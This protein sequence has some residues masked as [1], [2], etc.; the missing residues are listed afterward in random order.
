MFVK[1]AR[2]LPRVAV[3]FPELGSQEYLTDEEGRIEVELG[4]GTH[5]VEVR[6]GE[7]WGRYRLDADVRSSL[8]VVDTGARASS[9]G[10]RSTDAYLDFGDPRLAERYQ[11]AKL[12]GRGGMGVVVEATDTLL[13]RKVAIKMLNDQLHD[14]P[15]AE[16]IFLTEARAMAKLSHPN[17]VAVHDVIAGDSRTLMVVEYIEGRSLES[18]IMEAGDGLPEQTVVAVGASLC[19]AF[20]YLHS[21]GV[22]HR[23]LKPANVMIQPD[24]AL[25]LIDFGLARSLEHI[26]MRG[27][28]VRGTPAYMAPEQVLGGELG[29]AT[30]IY[31][32]GV[33]L[34]E[35]LSGRLPFETGNVA[36]AHVHTEPPRIDELVA[37]LDPGLAVLVHAC[38]AKDPADRPPGAQF[39]QD[40]LEA[41]AAGDDI[42]ARLTERFG[43]ASG[44]ARTASFGLSTHGGKPA[45]GGGV[46]RP[47]RG[48]RHRP[49]RRR[50]RRRGRGGAVFGP[51]TRRVAREGARHGRVGRGRA[52]WQSGDGRAA[53]DG[54]ATGQEGVGA[55]ARPSGRAG[56]PRASGR[57]HP[58]GACARRDR[59]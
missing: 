25:K 16:R 40:Q 5:V 34:F 11:V 1:E 32:I 24:G 43:G 22:I 28:S 54:T 51:Q 49:A 46:E 42:A 14:N 23:D 59:A 30:D 50:H 47:G 39:V 18:M 3:R 12:L 29:A 48:H 4:E 15:E 20:A 21:Q 41:L 55:G 19:R 2:P 13:K 10:A 53:E 52:A 31:Q 26:A 44:P 7:A 37:G 33:T 57:G 36:Y 27:T 6:D 9:M 8:L 17:L 45:P 35:A 58:G 56:R 38:M